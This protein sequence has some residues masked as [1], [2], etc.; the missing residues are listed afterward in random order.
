[1]ENSSSQL[2]KL[3]KMQTGT[4][5]EALSSGRAL[6]DLNKVCVHIKKPTLCTPQVGSVWRG[7]KANEKQAWKEKGNTV[8]FFLKICLE[9]ERGKRGNWDFIIPEANGFS[10][11]NMTNF[12]IKVREYSR[13]ARLS[14]GEGWEALSKGKYI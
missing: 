11:T 8:W 4:E 9:R 5:K 13:F 7:K 14:L 12:L 2:P 10:L 3:L 1:M 6:G